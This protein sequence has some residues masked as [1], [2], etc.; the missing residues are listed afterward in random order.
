MTFTLKPSLEL[1][2]GV[3]AVDVPVDAL[4][5]LFELST[6]LVWICS[7]NDL[8]LDGG[9]LWPRESA[10]ALRRGHQL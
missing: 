2:L 7:F 9:D 3:C 5:F 10:L 4:I 6:P 1:L 8:L